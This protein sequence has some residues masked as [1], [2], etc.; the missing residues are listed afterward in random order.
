MGKSQVWVSGLQG[1]THKILRGL[2]TKQGLP[3]WSAAY[4]RNLLAQ[5]PSAHSCETGSNIPKSWPIVMD[6]GL[7]VLC[8]TLFSS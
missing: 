8:H 3:T 7:M 2:F 1:L 5:I 6:L 4:S